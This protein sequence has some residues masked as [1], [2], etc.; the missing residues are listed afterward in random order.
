MYIVIELPLIIGVYKVQL[1]IN[2]GVH[3]VQLPMIT[4]VHKVQLF[5][6]TGVHTVCIYRHISSI[7]SSTKSD[8]S[9]SLLR[10]PQ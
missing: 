9:S 1:P 4:D 5:L 2:T 8:L 7:H 6:I 10:P 3:E